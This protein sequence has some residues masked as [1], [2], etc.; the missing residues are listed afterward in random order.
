[1]WKLGLRPCNSFSGSI[2]FE[3]LILCLCR[4]I[5]DALAKQSKEGCFFSYCILCM[6]TSWWWD[7]SFFKV[8]LWGSG[9]PFLWRVH[10]ALCAAYQRPR[11]I[12]RGREPPK[13]TMAS[14]YIPKFWNTYSLKWNCRASVPIPTFMFLWAIYIFSGSVCLFWCRKIGGPIV[15]I[16]KLLPD[17][18]IV[19]IGTEAAQFLFEEYIKSDF[20]RK[21]G[22]PFTLSPFSCQGTGTRR[23][24]K[25]EP[26]KSTY[27]LPVLCKLRQTHHHG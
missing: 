21:A 26:T 10:C 4:A 7:D 9:F 2:C 8:L 5:R 20:L 14:L 11:G 27:L 6:A 25:R 17:T 24:N 12:I 18:L 16:Y 15:G 22:N 19:E 3:F 13:P 1:M 23:R